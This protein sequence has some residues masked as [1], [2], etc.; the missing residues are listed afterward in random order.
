MICNEIPRNCHIF[1]SCHESVKS[2]AIPVQN[3]AKF[4]KSS[5]RISFSVARYPQFRFG[6]SLWVT[7]PRVKLALKTVKSRDSKLYSVKFVKFAFPKTHLFF[8]QNLRQ[9]MPET[10]CCWVHLGWWTLWRRQKR[11]LGRQPS[12]LSL[13]ENAFVFEHVFMLRGLA[14]LDFGLKLEDMVK[15]RQYILLVELFGWL[16]IPKILIFG[17]PKYLTC[18]FGLRYIVLCECIS[19]ISL[20]FWLQVVQQVYVM[21]IGLN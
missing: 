10:I 19:P 21:Q 7:G 6:G 15:Q 5:P 16:Y 20:H 14:N 4:E 13:G 2:E 1:S 18:Q 3:L 9:F 17:N 12:L 8:K 11:R